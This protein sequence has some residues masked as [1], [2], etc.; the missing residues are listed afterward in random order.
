LPGGDASPEVDEAPGRLGNG[1]GGVEE[2][3]LRVRRMSV[4]VLVGVLGLLDHGL[5]EGETANSPRVRE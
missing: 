5:L 3:L 2:E 4:Q 1:V